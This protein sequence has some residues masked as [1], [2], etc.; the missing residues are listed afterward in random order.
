MEDVSTVL[1]DIRMFLFLSIS[2]LNGIETFIAVA[3]H[4]Y[5]PALR[6]CNSNKGCRIMGEL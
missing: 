2:V 6:E 5:H 3:Q 4:Y 1:P